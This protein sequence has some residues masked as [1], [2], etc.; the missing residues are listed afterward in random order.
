MFY[1]PPTAFN[2]P[3]TTPECVENT[4]ELFVATRH[5]VRCTRTHQLAEFSSNPVF[6]ISLAILISQYK[7]N[8]THLFVATDNSH[9][10]NKTFTEWYTTTKTETRM[11][12]IDIGGDGQTR[13]RIYSID[14]VFSSDIEV[15]NEEMFSSKDIIICSI[16][17]FNNKIYPVI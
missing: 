15:V 1:L 10:I 11:K 3:A 2:L 5:N 6:Y 17:K 7:L 12:N 8:H 14:L 9:F 16:D 13:A 4:G